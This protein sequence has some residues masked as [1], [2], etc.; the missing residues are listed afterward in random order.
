MS[1]EIRE[2]L[3]YTRTHEWVCFEGELVTVGITDY[4]QD[5]LKDVVYVE[6]PEVGQEAQAGESLAVVESVKAVSDLYA[7]VDGE[8]L[9]VNE[10]LLDQPELLNEDPYG[11]AWVVKIKIAPGYKNPDLLEK[12][13]YAALVKEEAAK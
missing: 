8:V 11:E 1:W 4:A 13:G 2:G 3:K 7:P 10:L 9:E 6:L 12:D 5:M